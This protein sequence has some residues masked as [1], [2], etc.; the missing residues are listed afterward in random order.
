M[1]KSLKQIIYETNVLVDAHVQLR[2]FY[3][4]DLLDIIKI[5]AIDYAS[6]F[7]SINSA[8]N[9][10]NFE[11]FNLELF[12][13]DILA[14]DDSNRTDIE[15][16]T[17]RILNDL[18]TVIRYSTRWNDFSEVLTDVP[19]LKYYDNLQDRLSGWGA[20]LQLKVYRNDCLVGLPID[21]YDFDMA[22]DFE[23]TVLAIVKNTDNDILATKLVSDLDDTIIISDITVTDSDGSTYQQA[24]G[25][26][27][28]CTAGGGGG[29]VELNG[30]NIGTYTAPNTFA[31]NVT[32]DGNA[33]GT[34]NSGTSTWEVVSDPCL[35]ATYQIEDT[36]DN[37]LYSGSIA[38]GGNLAQVIQNSTV[39]IIDDSANT[40]YTVSTLAEGSDTQVIQD[41]TAV[42]KNTDNTILSTTSINAEASA[43]II[44]PDGHVHLKKESGGTIDNVFV[45][46]G[47][48][49]IYTVA[50]NDISVNGVLEFDI[51][52]TDSL[53]IRLRDTS[54]AV[55]TPNSI[56]EMGNHV[57]IV[58]PDS[59][60]ENSDATYTDTVISGGSLIL[61]DITVTDSDGSTYSQPSVNNVTCTPC[62][63]ATY[64]LEDSL[65]GALSS[66]SIPSGTNDVIVAPDATVE[67]SDAS[68]TDTV[69]SGG[70][71][72][73]PDSDIEVNGVLEGAIPS[74]Q[75]ADIQLT[76][77]VVSVTPTSVVVSGNTVT[78]EVPSGGG[79]PVG[80][81]LMKTGQTTSYRT[82]DDAD[83]S[84]EG[85]ATDFFTLASNNP[86]GT[87]A[88][89]TDELGGSTYTNNIVI[90]WSTYDGSTVLG[91]YRI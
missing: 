49:E 82:G 75:T 21:D 54:N 30:T 72:V 8:S 74:V 38:S 87:T 85:R 88:R 26:N 28:I 67:N 65:G 23:L 77:G 34:W 78:I 20:T 15:N 32:L 35:D 83:T 59:T 76:D 13:F 16:T 69:V 58:M 1:E 68:Y 10:A 64:D 22:G 66:G 24:A 19:Q 29:D 63:D 42:L 52:A 91:Y 50:D 6:C 17:K 14:T 39:K 86:F 4:G 81:T 48:T 73:L 3:Y 71:L 70:T 79:A 46:S 31:A 60:V 61:P 47:V 41:S 37:I 33:S 25:T 57:T 55:V 12:V 56:T 80:A 5:G 62:A 27:V 51:H 40:L 7:L 11:T 84:S 44:A 9:N 90:D 45:P 2:S 18:I 36:D 53:D 89:F 43:D